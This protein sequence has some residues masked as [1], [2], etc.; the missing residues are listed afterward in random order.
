M[1][2]RRMFSKDIVSTR[3]F[4]EMPPSA[5]AL[6]YQLGIEADDDGF[7]DPYIT[8]LATKSQ[9]DDLRILVAK[10]FVIEFDNK[11]IVIRHWK[12]HNYIRKDT[13]KETQ[14]KEY[15]RL[16]IE[17]ENQEFLLMDKT[18]QR[19]VN[20]PSTQVRI[21]KVRLGKDKERE[22]NNVNYIIGLFEKVNPSYKRLYANKT[23]RSAIDR[24]IKE[25]GTSSLESIIQKLPSIVTQPYAPKITTP[26]QLEKDFGK[27]ILYIKQ[28]QNSN[29]LKR[30]G[31]YV[32]E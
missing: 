32:I 2:N 11:I 10:G 1:A 13:Y 5:R 22:Q 17:G 18:I 6:Y 28:N 23:Q 7:I 25:H 21:G 27:L 16:L 9:T 19:P 4:L 20:D 14:Y 8:M 24:M 31:V 15:K 30:G 3:D 29:N 26:L 12:Q